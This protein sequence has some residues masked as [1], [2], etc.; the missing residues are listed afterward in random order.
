MARQYYQTTS[1]LV[2]TRVNLSNLLDQVMPEIQTLLQD[3]PNNHKL[4][5]FVDKY[6]HFQNILDMGEKK[7]AADYCKWAKKKGYRYN[8]RKAAE[9]FALAQNGIPTLPNSETVKIAVREAVRMIHSIEESIL[10]Q[11]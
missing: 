1:I 6:I 2:K 5:E 4:T 9:I 7:F 11:M 10:T 8:E 3:Q